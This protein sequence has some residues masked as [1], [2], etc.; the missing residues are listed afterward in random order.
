[1]ELPDASPSTMTRCARCRSRRTCRTRC[2]RLDGSRDRSRRQ[3][4]TDSFSCRGSPRMV[5]AGAH[6]RPRSMPSD[7]RGRRMSDR[8]T[9]LADVLLDR[10][11][12]DG[13]CACERR[14]CTRPRP[15]A[16][17]A[18]GASHARDAEADG[19]NAVLARRPR[20]RRRR[21]RRRALARHARRAPC[22]SPAFPLPSRTTSPRVDCQRRAA[23]GCSKV[24]SVRSRRPP[25][26]GC[27]KPV[28]SSL[29]RRTWTNS[30]WDRPPKTARSVRR[31]I[32]I[33]LTRV[34]GGSS[35]GSAAA[36]AAGV[37]PIA[38]GSET[39]GSVRQ[40]AAFCGIVGV[41]PTYGR[42]SRFGLVAFASSLDHIGVFGRTVDDAAL[43][44]CK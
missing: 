44:C 42:V 8:R 14:P 12:R 19:L 41:K 7:R 39:G 38:L 9:P 40:P 20:W 23:R 1:M 21:R 5:P 28:R 32:R 6:G 3:C 35:G 29:A 33:D 24:T 16:H 37:S 17:A 11:G 30:R 22:R 13:G 34:P 27:A 18:S 2:R 25:C 43:A 26:A 10:S 36:V 4:V 31:A 15:L